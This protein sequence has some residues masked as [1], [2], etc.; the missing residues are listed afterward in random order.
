VLVNYTR[1]KSAL[2]PPCFTQKQISSSERSIAKQNIDIAK[3]SWNSSTDRGSANESNRQSRKQSPFAPEGFPVFPK[4]WPT[5]DGSSFKISLGDC[6][7]ERSI[8][9]RCARVSRQP[10]L[11]SRG[12]TSGKSGNVWELLE[13]DDSSMKSYQSKWIVD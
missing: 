6:A 4:C 1:G 9:S 7:N 10:A 2:P 5:G 12:E 8:E 11:F 3:L 13:N